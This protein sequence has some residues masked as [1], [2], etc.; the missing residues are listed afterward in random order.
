MNTVQFSLNKSFSRVC[1]SPL[2]RQ[3]SPMAGMMFT[4]FRFA[5]ACRMFSGNSS[6]LRATRG[7]LTFVW[8]T[9]L[10]ERDKRGGER[11]R[12]RQERGGAERLHDSLL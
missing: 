3:N 11:E 1:L 10:K 12:E 9:G 7:K 6:D 5:V 8:G 4:V 2:K